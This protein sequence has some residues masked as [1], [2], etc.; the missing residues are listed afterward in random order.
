M[1]DPPDGQR[2][3]GALGTYAHESVIPPL[4]AWGNADVVGAATSLG[5]NYGRPPSLIPGQ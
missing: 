2:A 5:G 4:A 3:T 1:C